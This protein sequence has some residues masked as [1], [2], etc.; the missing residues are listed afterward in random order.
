MEITRFTQSGSRLG[1]RYDFDDG[2]ELA[3]RK[4]SCLNRQ[5]RPLRAR[6]KHFVHL[7]RNGHQLEN[8]LG[9]E[10]FSNYR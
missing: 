9:A 3:R 8:P 1:V 5:Q 4:H 2:G 6:D 7:P 10:D